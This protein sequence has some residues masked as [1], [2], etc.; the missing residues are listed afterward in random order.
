MGAIDWSFGLC[1]LSFYN[2]PADWQIYLK[3][4]KMAI[5]AFL[6]MAIFTY[7]IGMYSVVGTTLNQV[8][9]YT[10]PKICV[11]FPFLTLGGWNVWTAKDFL[12]P[13]PT[14]GGNGSMLWDVVKD[15]FLRQAC[16]D[17]WFPKVWGQSVGLLQAETPLEELKS[18]TAT[19]AEKLLDLK[20]KQKIEQH[21]YAAETWELKERYEELA[22]QYDA[23]KSENWTVFVAL[24]L[25]AALLLTSAY[26]YCL[27]RRAAVTLSSRTMERRNTQL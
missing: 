22:K 25:S 4:H 14:Y 24:F 10:I 12:A 6:N 18:E 26:F 7:G 13:S 1:G 21:R 11:I 8:A 3:G 5:F 17:G 2:L 20:M 27:R 16:W 9:A 19:N 15:K 23:K